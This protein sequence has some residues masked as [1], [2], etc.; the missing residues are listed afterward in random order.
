M[1]SLS[2]STPR[3][4]E[5]LP[6]S[7]LTFH[8]CS[9]T[10]PAIMHPELLGGLVCL[11]EKYADCDPLVLH[12]VGFLVNIL[13]TLSCTI[14]VGTLHILDAAIIARETSVPRLKL[15]QRVVLRILHESQKADPDMLLF[16]ADVLHVLL[17]TPSQDAS[18]LCRVG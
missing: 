15:V 18:G 1:R 12:V 3:H 2:G 13:S 6:V 5:A 14:L 8:N 16:I 4:S 9:E 17:L 10:T 11:R 7:F